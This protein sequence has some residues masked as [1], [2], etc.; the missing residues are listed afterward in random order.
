MQRE[1]YCSVRKLTAI[2]VI[3]SLLL[4][5][6]VPIQSGVVSAS[7]VEEAPSYQEDFS[8]GLGDWQINAGQWTTVNGELGN[9]S[10][11]EYGL[12]QLAGDD[13]VWK[14]QVV[15]F[16]FRLDSMPSGTGTGYGGLSIRTGSGAA[17]YQ[18]LISDNRIA[19]IAAGATEL[20]LDWEGVE[21]GTNYDFRVEA[22]G[23]VVTVQ[24]KRSSE[25]TYQSVR[26]EQPT[27]IQDV[28][29]QLQVFSY[30]ATASF[31]NIKVWSESEEEEEETTPQY[32][33][34]FS[35]GLGSWQTKDGQWTT[36]NG[37]L[38]N[39]SAS[40]YGR[41]ELDGTGYV[42]KDQVVEFTFR[43]DS[44][45][46]GT[47]TGYGGLSIRTGSGAAAP[48]QLL[49]S[50]N[51]IAYIAAGA[52]ELWL[53]WEGVE[54]GTNYDFRVVAEGS[55]VTVQYKR[56]SED[57]YQSVRMEQPMDIQDVAGKLQVFSYNATASFDNIKVW[58]EYVPKEP[59]LQFEE[60]FSDGMN[61]WDG[62]VGWVPWNIVN[63]KLV[64]DNSTNLGIVEAKGS[65]AV[66]HNFELSF[67]F[68]R[69]AT[70]S[71]DNH[72]GVQIRHDKQTNTFGW[73]LIRP[74]YISYY[75]EDIGEKYLY[76]WE[77]TEGVEYELKAV[78]NG[79]EL[80]I[81]L[82]NVGDDSFTHVATEPNI[83]NQAG[84]F[85]FTTINMSGSF[86][87]V[88]V[89]NYDYTELALSSKLS[90]IEVGTEQTLEVVNHTGSDHLVW[91]SSDSERIQ[92]DQN[93]KIT[94][95]RKG[96]AVIT[97][98]TVDEQYADTMTVIAFIR[99]T[100]INFLG[101][102]STLY[103]GEVQEL[104]VGIVPA[105]ADNMTTIWETSNP[106]V[107]T[108]VGN[109]NVARAART[110][111]EGTAVITVRTVDGGFIASKTITV[112]GPPNQTP[113]IANMRVEGSVKDIPSHFLGVNDVHGY[114]IGIID[115]HNPDNFVDMLSDIRFR[116]IRGP[117]GLD[118]NF[119]LPDKGVL[120]TAKDTLTETEVEKYTELYGEHLMSLNAWMPSYV[121]EDKRVTYPDVLKL[122]NEYDIPY[123]YNLN[124]IAYTA[125]E[126][127]EQVGTIKQHLREGQQLFLEYGNELY[128]NEYKFPFPTVREYIAK[129][130]EVYEAIHPLYPDVKFGIV[131]IDQGSVDYMLADPNNQQKEGQTYEEYLSTQ[132]G[133]LSIWNEELQ[134]DQSF[135][136]AVII[137][138]YSN[139]DNIV[140]LS[141][142][143]MYNDLFKANALRKTTMDMTMEM[144]P[145]KEAWITEWG[146]LPLFVF[147]EQDTSL[148]AR[149]QFMKTQ[150]IGAYYLDMGFSM[151]ED[152][153]ITMA[154]YFHTSDPQ[155]FGL[156]QPHAD[157]GFVKLPS[158]YGIQKL[159]ELLVEHNK[160]YKI[161]LS[162]VNARM[163]AQDRTN[164]PVKIEDVGAWGL[165][166]SSGMKT[167]VLSNRTNHP[168][169]VELDGYKLKAEWEYG[170]LDAAEDFLVNPNAS[171]NDPPQYGV[172]LPVELS[173]VMADKVQVKPY[174]IM[175]VEVDKLPV[176][177]NPST[178]IQPADKATALPVKN[179]N[180]VL[181]HQ[182]L[183]SEQR[184][185]SDGT[186]T[187]HLVIPADLILQALQQSGNGGITIDTRGL[188]GGI[189]V[190]FPASLLEQSANY[191][192]SIE[193]DATTYRLPTK[194]VNI[195]ELARTLG[196]DSKDIS[197]VTAIHAYSSEQ[198]QEMN[199]A[200]ANVG[201]AMLTD[202]VSFEVYV[203][204]G[205]RSI[206]VTHFN[207]TY[208]EREFKLD[209]EPD[210]NRTTGVMYD[211]ATGTFSYV[212]TVFHTAVDG[213]ATAT[214]KRPGNSLYAIAT[215]DK[216][217][218]DVHNHWA[219]DSIELLAS[220]WIVNGKSEMSFAPDDHITRAEFTALL[221]RGLGLKEVSGSS[222][223][224]DITDANW[225]AGAV[226][227]AKQAGIIDGF[228][229]GRFQPHAKITR[230][231]M[232]MMINSA[233][234]FTGRTTSVANKEASLM[235][236]KDQGEISDWARE[237]VAIAVL[238]GIIRGV[239]NEHT[240]KIKALAT[241]AQAVAML[242]RTLKHADMINS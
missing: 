5:L 195:Q 211:P 13:Y 95:L 148:Q 144:F 205:D 74:N 96:S 137:H 18:L 26:M 141:T 134:K 241:R 57:T 203:R 4:T 235:I 80:K 54:L 210:E 222:S 120:V 236:F 158:F 232:A 219:K 35:N 2:V 61:L 169:D 170:G 102:D 149:R 69:V 115:E 173:S 182:L 90:G 171:W 22:E 204:S 53:D 111:G 48:Y 62:S 136:D 162:Q 224:T 88:K 161:D 154:H 65:N 151:L 3:L 41:A 58:G 237:A 131:S 86:D 143:R 229:D 157:E 155:G 25:D 81:Y 194:A 56:S 129:S 50:D 189:E 150:A 104:V 51:R 34:D 199:E 70:A 212:P 46:S 40:E 152:N 77:F 223:F 49:I 11:S 192:I 6:I 31:D 230:E 84:K 28:A 133:R 190:A 38:A 100:G 109:S 166:D 145:G 12:A 72:M 8:G 127:A 135:Y 93:G 172:T 7:S 89:S 188:G 213:S 117:G 126:L 227:A 242:Q 209:N 87:N 183:Q 23:S 47:G 92:V 202:W 164:V 216:T 75:E 191:V 107:I 234:N 27:D 185:H 228:Q 198:A 67:Q 221:V 122:S 1:V 101:S 119:Y 45:P 160:Y 9:Q 113:T 99:P 63:G 175:V 153:T 193:T 17:P 130:K 36:D 39:Q 240:L 178:V 85:R 44:M 225:Y 239:G 29:G 196:V 19:Y 83:V 163:D 21:L 128:D 179:G 165:G 174:S 208:V 181:G 105:N 98:S 106:D 197:L 97:V 43:L 16:T 114:K 20:W 207:N 124:I 123:V 79:P 146:F 217:F 10:A 37:E 226:E 121:P 200:I 103:L 64:S 112:T 138:Q 110:E 206:E 233:L 33:E 186:S 180:I 76:S 55:A 218:A 159:S 15:E 176:T 52:T 184:T 59:M 201:G 118:G 68:T 82:R 91:T 66:W 42:W 156:V 215:N 108:L 14:D 24:Y 78:A 177:S 238:A 139:V 73:I 32:A 167:L 187:W 116:S 147:M 94:A 132:G 231:Q 214:L 30:N 60:D 140:D 71:S 142:T 125:E 220:K 168:V